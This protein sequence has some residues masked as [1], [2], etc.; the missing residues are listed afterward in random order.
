MSA[1]VSI[2][3][4][5]YNVEKYLERCL[6]SVVNQTYKNLEII[7]V[8]DGSTD[9]SSE[10]SQK[11]QKKDNRIKVIR[12]E[13][14]GLGMARNTGI[15]NATGD[16]I[17]FLDSDDYVSGDLVEKCLKKQQENNA[18]VVLYGFSRVD[19]D[20]RVYFSRVPYLKSGRLVET[21]INDEVLPALMAS[22]GKKVSGL[23]MSAWACMYSKNIIDKHHWTFV[24]EREIIAEDVYSLLQYYSYV[25]NVGV[26]EES[27]YFYCD[28]GASLTHTYRTDRF[29]KINSFLEKTISRTQEFG[30]GQKV[31]VCVYNLYM[32]FLIAAMKLVVLDSSRNYRQKRQILSECKIDSRT[33]ELFKIGKMDKKRMYYWLIVSLMK[34]KM[35]DII[36]LFMR[37]KGKHV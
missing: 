15:E 36:Y 27:L 20:N 7:I 14:A 22:M 32:S 17:F 19:A 8:D 31:R 1:L 13:N 23:W 16:F 28:N 2:V 9:S 18:D 35:F 6:D 11:W 5:V 12:K 26:V 33:S 29:E 4:P 25:K 34:M 21:D 3:L 37:I 10:I 24:S 30:Y